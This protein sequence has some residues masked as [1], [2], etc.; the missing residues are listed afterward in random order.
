MHLTLGR[1]RADCRPGHQVSNVLRYDRIKE[2]RTGKDAHLSQ[3]KQQFACRVQPVTDV[4]CPVQVGIVN[5]ALPSERCSRFLEVHAHHK[6]DA[7]F[8]LV[9]KFF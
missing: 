2:L 3:V 1:P 4:E 6:K 8:H 9:G 5:Q 7:F